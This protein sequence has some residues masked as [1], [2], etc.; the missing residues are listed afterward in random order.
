[1]S[2]SIPPAEGKIPFQRE[3][4]TQPGTPGLTL[5]PGKANNMAAYRTQRGDEAHAHG[6]PPGRERSGVVTSDAVPSNGCTSAGAGNPE[7]AGE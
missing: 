5:T 2:A 7:A 3:T 1:M 4:S 6:A